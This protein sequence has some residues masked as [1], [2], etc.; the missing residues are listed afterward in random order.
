MIVMALA[1]LRLQER[2]EAPLRRA[3]AGAGICATAPG[4]G[5]GSGGG[6]PYISALDDCVRCRA[7]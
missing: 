3:A 5:G 6:G 2:L 1:W 4:G 7:P